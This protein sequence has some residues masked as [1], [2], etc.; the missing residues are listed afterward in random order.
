MCRRDDVTSSDTN[1]II[2]T[3]LHHFDLQIT[4]NSTGFKC[5]FWM[6]ATTNNNN[7]FSFLFRLSNGNVL[8]LVNVTRP[9]PATPKQKRHFDT[10][11]K[12]T[13]CLPVCTS[14]RNGGLDLC[15]LITR[16]RVNNLQR[17]PYRSNRFFMYGG[18]FCHNNWIVAA[19]KY[20]TVCESKC[21]DVTNHAK[22]AENLCE[23]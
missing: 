22:R 10:F 4:E 18:Y 20:G 15:A 2:P 14:R 7:T 23:V 11:L 5:V 8:G 9:W 16:L 6:K 13:A 3:Y 21:C 19:S 17:P 12:A 1:S